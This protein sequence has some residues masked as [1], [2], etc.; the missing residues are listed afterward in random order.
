MGGGQCIHWYTRFSIIP[1]KAL[2]APEKTGTLSSLTELDKKI[3]A[4]LRIDQQAL[5]QRFHRFLQQGRLDTDST[6]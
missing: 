4:G 2:F 5:I 6:Y 3:S 1:I